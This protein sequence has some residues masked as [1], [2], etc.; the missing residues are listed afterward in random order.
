MLY[1][2]VCPLDHNGWEIE[3]GRCRSIPY[4]TITT[5]KNLSMQSWK[6]RIQ[7]THS[8]LYKKLIKN[9][10]YEFLNF[11]RKIVCEFLNFCCTGKYCK[12][13]QIHVKIA[14][15]LIFLEIQAVSFMHPMKSR[16]LNIILLDRVSSALYITH[17]IHDTDYHV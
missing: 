8:F 7:Y 17:V 15:F 2:V 11:C 3:I 10:A 13:P 14:S 5:D 12:N 9:P 6:F 4:N 1:F 16:T